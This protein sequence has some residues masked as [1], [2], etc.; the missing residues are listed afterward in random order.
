VL[1]IGSW[2][3]EHQVT[4]SVPSVVGRAG[5][6]RRLSPDLSTSEQQALL[7]SAETLRSAVAR[8]RP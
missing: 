8:L 5:V 2:N 1:P 3:P 4:L 7:K 6:I